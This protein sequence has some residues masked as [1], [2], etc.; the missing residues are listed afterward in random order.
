MSITK[1]E[2]DMEAEFLDRVFYKYMIM[3]SICKQKKEDIKRG[4]PNYMNSVCGIYCKD[5]ATIMSLNGFL[6]KWKVYINNSK[7]LLDY[8]E[9]IIDKITEYIEHIDTRFTCYNDWSLRELCGCINYNREYRE[10]KIWRTYMETTNGNGIEG[11]MMLDD[12][13]QISVQCKSA[14]EYKYMFKNSLNWRTDLNSHLEILR[15]HLKYFKRVPHKNYRDNIL[16]QLI[17]AT[18]SDCVKNIIEY[19]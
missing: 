17:F 10:N 16:I 9:Y 13:Q 8:R 3:M 7:E 11:D 14:D 4:M 6:N 15:E 1:S 12:L 18:N 19:L 5:C 2:F